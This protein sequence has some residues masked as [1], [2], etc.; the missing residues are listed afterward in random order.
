MSLIIFHSLCIFWCPKI[1]KTH[2]FYPMETS[3]DSGVVEIYTFSSTPLI[4][5]RKNVFLFKTNQLKL[6]LVIIP[7]L[8]TVRNVVK[9]C[10]VFIANYYYSI[11]IILLSLENRDQHQAC[12]I[13]IQK[14]FVWNILLLNHFYLKNKERIEEENRLSY[15]Q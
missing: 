3:H 9:I 2:F 8:I 11:I 7:T 13:F 10:I 12:L 14:I 6:A 15:M 1:I 5:K 4:F